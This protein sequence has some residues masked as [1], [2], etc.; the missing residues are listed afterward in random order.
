MSRDMPHNPSDYL[1]QLGW[2][3][4]FEEHFQSLKTEGSIPARVVSESKGSFQ[5]YCRYGELRAKVSGKMRYQSDRE[6]RFPAVGDWVAIEPQ[7]GEGKGVI[8]AV[9]PRNS[10]FSRKVAGGRTEE[11]V[12]AA[13]VDTVFIVSGLDGGRNFNLRRMERYL[14]LAQNSGAPPVM[15]LN[16]LDLYPDVREYIEKVEAIATGVPIH[17]VSAKERTGL[18]ALTGYVTRGKTAAFL[19]SSGV[20]KSALINA[21]LG[22]ERQGT[23]EVRQYDRTGRHTTTRRELFLLPGGGAVIDTSGMRE[24]QMWASED[25]LQSSFNEVAVLAGKCRFRDCTHNN[26]PGC[27]VIEAIERGALEAGRL[28]SFRKLQNEVRYIAS[29]EEHSTRLLEK[30]KWKKISKWSKQLRKRTDQ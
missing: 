2:G 23:G 20:G 18:D 21:L 10:R 8:H 30:A 24:I 4:F 27:A 29:R 28:E 14:T 26:E 17:A 16:K 19:G 15:V 3:P 1:G 7:A 9:L 12:V 13:N 5:V 6:N 25:D 22:A 11:Q